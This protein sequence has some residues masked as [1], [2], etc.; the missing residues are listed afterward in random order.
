MHS[1]LEHSAVKIIMQSK[2]GHSE[3]SGGKWKTDEKKK[4]KNNEVLICVKHLHDLGP[5]EGIYKRIRHLEARLRDCVGTRTQ[6]V[7]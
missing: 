3:L 4:W 1:C 5:Q 6:T 2:R 7:T